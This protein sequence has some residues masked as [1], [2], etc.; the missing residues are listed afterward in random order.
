MVAVLKTTL[1]LVAFFTKFTLVDRLCLVFYPDQCPAELDL[2]VPNALVALSLLM[3]F[4]SCHFMQLLFRDNPMPRWLE[5]IIDAFIIMYLTEVTIRQMWIPLLDVAY[6][7]CKLVA[8]GLSELVSGEMESKVKPIVM[9]LQNDAMNLIQITIALVFV[10]IML[11]VTGTLRSVKM[12]YFNRFGR[13][14]GDDCTWNYTKDGGFRL[15]NECPVAKE[16]PVPKQSILKTP[17][18]NSF[19][20]QSNYSLRTLKLVKKPSPRSVS[21]KT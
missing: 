6:W 8:V 13:A 17:P 18:R 10:Y 4:G 2:S 1:G 5:N 12:A 7:L 19:N 14:P 3:A 15:P 9:W 16:S 20:P 21:F 11:H